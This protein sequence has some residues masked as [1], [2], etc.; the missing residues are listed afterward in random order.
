MDYALPQPGTLCKVVPHYDGDRSVGGAMTTSNCP[1]FDPD[2][3]RVEVMPFDRLVLVLE[4][5][6]DPVDPMLRVIG[7][8]GRLMWI[9]WGNLQ[10]I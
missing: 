8:D 6:D 5:V 4:L 9:G 7:G 3:E 1:Y 10:V 2:D